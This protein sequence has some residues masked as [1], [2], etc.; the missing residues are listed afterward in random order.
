M[1]KL[2]LL[3]LLPILFFSCSDDKEETQDYTSFVFIQTVDNVLPH[4]VAAYLDKDSHFIKIA[5]LGTI[6]L[7]NSSK[8]ITIND[9][10]I[11]DIYFFTDYN[12]IVRFD[13]IYKLKKNTKSI[14]KLE[15]YT[16]GIEITDKTDPTQYP[17]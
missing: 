15:K 11:T 12:N 14:F 8:E 7:D 13:A 6:S 10:N 17:Q 16:K 9:E 4:C 3:L 2:S 1:K 5:D